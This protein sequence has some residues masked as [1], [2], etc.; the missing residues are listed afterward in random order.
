MTIPL[1]P[2]G[3]VSLI[4]KVVILFL[5]I[6]GLPSFKGRDENKNTSRHGYFTVLALI[7]HTILIIVV[8]I[9]TFSNGIGELGSLPPLYLFNVLSH[10]VLGTIAEVMGLIIIFYWLLKSPKRRECVKMRRWMTPIFVIWVISLING[11][12][13]HIVGMIYKEDEKH[14]ATV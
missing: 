12:L 9:P 8:M 10:A 3:N 13:I 4:L 6:I 14:I 2:V 7:L 11:T 1:D 5:L